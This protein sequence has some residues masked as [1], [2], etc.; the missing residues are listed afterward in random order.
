MTPTGEPSDETLVARCQMGDYAAF[1]ILYRRWQK[2]ILG[3]L[4]QLT[5]DR[6]A[7]ACLSQE[8]FLRVFEHSERFDTSRR[9]TTWFYTI[10]RNGALDWL[11]S[12]HR[13]T[14][15]S[16]SG[17]AD[18]DGVPIDHAAPLVPIETILSRQ[19]SL[20][21][22]REALEGLTPVHREIIEL[23]IFRELSYEEASDIIGGGVS[24]GTLRSRLHHALRH[25]RN[26][27]EGKDL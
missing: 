24:L 21:I 12:K 1:E 18:Q 22:L 9:F 8:T 16:L 2:P 17:I 19:E 10:A 14:S 23:I 5:R 15:M 6:E 26:A 4:T 11:T 7:A 3:Y 13:T 25:L 20:G 27:L